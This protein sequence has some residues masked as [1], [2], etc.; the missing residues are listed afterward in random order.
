MMQITGYKIVYDIYDGK[1]SVDE[2]QAYDLP[3]YVRT[4]IDNYFDYLETEMSDNEE[5]EVA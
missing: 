3:E 5:S 1:K 2:I 4:A